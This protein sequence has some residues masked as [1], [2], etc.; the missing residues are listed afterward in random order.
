[1][2]ALR[3]LRARTLDDAGRLAG[4]DLARGLAVFGMFAAH[5]LVT[6]HFDAAQ[7]ATWVDLVNGRSSIL[8]A[9]LAGVSIA[10]MSGARASAG[11]SPASGRTLVV[12]RRRL[13]VRAV[14]IWGIG[15]L[16]NATGV[17]VYVILPAYGILFLLAVPLLRLSASTLWVLAAV[18]GVGA[19]WL[20]PL[21]DRVLVAAG[22][23]GGDLV[24][25]L[26]WHYPFLL[27][28]AFLI[29]GLAAAR[30]DLRS[31]RTLVALAVGGA[32]CA[33]AAAAASTVIDVD[34]DSFLGRVLA[35]GAHSGGMLEAVGSGG[36]ALAVVGLCLLICRTPARIVLL[37]VRAVGSMP[38]TAYV[39]QIAAWAVWASFALGDVGDLS[40]FRALQPFWPF[41]AATL[42]FCTVWAL[43]L[44]RGPVERAVAYATRVVIPG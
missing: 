22:P 13:V 1:M 36:F 5:L 26:G 42:V 30:S 6:P 24:L 17:P 40:G 15:M 32:A 39:G 31:P 20:L 44:G 8:F 3:P 14:I 18:V 41:V 9:T 38:L 27:W 23:V 37:P 28:A 34:E 4:V 10:L 25:L 12:A 11:S 21:A 16:L 7:P 19:P 35:D 29:A 2:T 43:L 33:I